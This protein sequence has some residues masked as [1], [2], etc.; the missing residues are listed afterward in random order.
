M[1]SEGDRKALYTGD[2]VAGAGDAKILRSS[3]RTRA[4]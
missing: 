1:A 2:P 4:W 3:L